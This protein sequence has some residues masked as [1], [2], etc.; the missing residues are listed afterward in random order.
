[1]RKV[2]AMNRI[3]FKVPPLYRIEWIAMVVSKILGCHC[4]P[5]MQFN[6]TEENRSVDPLGNNWWMEVDGEHIHIT[7]RYVT[8]ER[9]E[10]YARVIEHQTGLTRVTR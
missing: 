8:G 5:E 10:A 6:W 4:L 1:M 2:D 9:L 3:T 7:A